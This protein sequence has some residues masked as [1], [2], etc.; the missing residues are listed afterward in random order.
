MIELV[1]LACLA[2]GGT[3]QERIQSFLPDVGIMGCMITA[4]AQLA[5]W[6]EANPG[7]RIETWR[8]MYEGER[9]LDA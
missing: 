3:C 5:A 8:C 4:Q 1:F 9:E 6:S 7:Y 2:A